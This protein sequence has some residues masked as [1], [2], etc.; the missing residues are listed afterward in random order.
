[1]SWNFLATVRLRQRVTNGPGSRAAGVAMA[2]KLIESAQTRRRAVNAPPSSRWSVPAR[3]SRTASSSNDPTNQRVVTASR[4]TRRSTGLDCS[5]FRFLARCR[6]YKRLPISPPNAPARTT[7]LITACPSRAHSPRATQRQVDVLAAYVAARGSVQDAAELVGIRRSTVERHFADLR[8]RSGLTTEQLIDAGRVSGR[9]VDPSL[10]PHC[11]VP[12][13]YRRCPVP[14]S[15]WPESQVVPTP[16]AGRRDVRPEA[17]RGARE[18][19]N[20]R[21]EESGLDEPPDEIPI[22]DAARSPG[23][24]ATRQHDVATGLVQLLGDLAAGLAAPDH[25]HAAGRQRFGVPIVLD[26]DLREICR[27][28]G[29]PGRPMRSLE[30]TVGKDQAGSMPTSLREG[31]PRTRPSSWAFGPAP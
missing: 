7:S 26:I 19:G 23:R 3:Y 31:Q 1:M 20:G 22:A 9:L 5:P 2:F 6:N 17:G 28:A 29:C 25:E 27:Q 16:M 13:V 12:L 24:P 10:E 30:G 15:T 11:S 18:G 4:V 14:R 8:A 21:V